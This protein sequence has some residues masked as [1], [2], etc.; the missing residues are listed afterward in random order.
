MAGQV[1]H[2]S[3]EELAAGLAL[4]TDVRHRVVV[5][6]DMS[7]RLTGA[8]RR[9]APGGQIYEDGDLS[10][11][12]PGEVCRIRYVIDDLAGRIKE[13]R[14]EI[15][16]RAD[17]GNPVARIAL[18]PPQFSHGSHTFDWNGRCPEGELAG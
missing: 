5:P 9:F 12:S 18:E 2:P 17:P 6:F 13:A 11:S 1:H 10:K 7:V 8:T 15:A 4:E 16:R 3:A 14:L